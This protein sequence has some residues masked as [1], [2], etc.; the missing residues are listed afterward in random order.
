MHC[1]RLFCIFQLNK[2]S[3]HFFCTRWNSRFGRA[4]A[5]YVFFQAENAAFI[6]VGAYIHD[7]LRCAR[8]ATPSVDASNLHRQRVVAAAEA[9]RCGNTLSC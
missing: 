6:I 4:I 5:S 2:S 7:A 8:A 3:I 9:N 1:A